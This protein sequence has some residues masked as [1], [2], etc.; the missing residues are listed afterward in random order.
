[1][2]FFKVYFCNTEIVIIFQFGGGIMGPPGVSYCNFLGPPGGPGIDGKAGPPG[3][4]VS[5][6]VEHEAYYDRP[7]L[8]SSPSQVIPTHP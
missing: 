6:P 2:C 4:S 3:T 8:G 7:D 1:L 5:Q